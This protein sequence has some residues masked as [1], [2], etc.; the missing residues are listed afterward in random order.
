MSIINTG[1]GNLSGAINSKNSY[2]P[3]AHSCSG[4]S[5]LRAIASLGQSPGNCLSPSGP[6][7]PPAVLKNKN[8]VKLR[9]TPEIRKQLVEVY[10]EDILKLQDAIERDLSK[11]LEVD[12]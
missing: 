9:P 5:P 8:L 2:F 12:Y 1:N 10:R 3:R 11:W 7:S 6:R 4:G